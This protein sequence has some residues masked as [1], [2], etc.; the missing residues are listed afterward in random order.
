[1]KFDEVLRDLAGD[2]ID[3]ANQEFLRQHDRHDFSAFTVDR[4]AI[5]QGGHTFRIKVEFEPNPMSALQLAVQR[6]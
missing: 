5:S 1:M 6:N 3:Q 4:S 2:A